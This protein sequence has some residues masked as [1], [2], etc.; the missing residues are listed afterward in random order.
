MRTPSSSSLAL[1]SALLFVAC[2]SESNLGPSAEL[3]AGVAGDATSPGG[4]AEAVD[5]GSDPADA[6]PRADVPPPPDAASGRDAAPARDSGPSRSEPPPLRPYSGGTCPPITSGTT[7]STAVNQGFISAGDTRSF[8]LLVP[9][10]YDATRSYPLVFA[11]HWLN[12]SSNSFV[13]DGELESAVEEMGF[14]AVLPDKLLKANGDK[15]YL[16]DWPFVETMNAD[17]ELTYFDD[18]LTCVSEQ[19]NVDAK[20]VY[21]IGVSAGALWLTFMMSTDRVEYLAAVESLSGG[22][23]AIGGLWSIQYVPQSYKF[24]AMV[25]WGGPTDRLGVN[26]D[27]ASQSLR[28]ALLGNGHF[29]L[30]CTHDSGHSM[31]PIM[32]PAGSSTKFWSLWRF[33]LDH[34]YGEPSPYPG[35]GIPAGFPDWCSIP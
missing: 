35:S 10:T 14:I 6:G 31:P 16:F 17:K 12:A 27:A 26:F 5:L 3:D 18:L 21:G 24:P 23:G 33:M 30:T 22:L 28:D 15:A 11:W 13:R 19:Y 29:V 20:R 1:A 9:S 25:L 7:S 4:D 8:R 32:A 34:P 2:S